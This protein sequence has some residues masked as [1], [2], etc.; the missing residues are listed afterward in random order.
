MKFF[1]AKFSR[2]RNECLCLTR[3]KAISFE[4]RQATKILSYL[5]LMNCSLSFKLDSTEKEMT[6]ASGHALKIPVIKVLP[7]F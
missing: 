5:T 3:Q 6:N 4:L 1:L 2:L 7:S